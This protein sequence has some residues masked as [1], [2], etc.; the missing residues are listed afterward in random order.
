MVEVVLVSTNRSVLPPEQ[1]ADR[2]H[3]VRL[4]DGSQRNTIRS[5]LRV[6]EEVVAAATGPGT[7]A[8]AAEP[9]ILAQQPARPATPAKLQPAKST[10]AVLENKAADSSAAAAPAAGATAGHASKTEPAAEAVL[11]PAQV[12]PS[13]Q[14]LAPATGSPPRQSPQ[15]RKTAR[16]PPS[17]GP[18][19]PTAH[20][21]AARRAAEG[22]GGDSMSAASYKLMVHMWHQHRAATCDWWGDYDQ[23]DDE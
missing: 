11:V 14:E 6:P 5:R 20:P 13:V 3:T 7:V 22:G 2:G 19:E 4:P 10:L 9:V 23:C 18:S 17:A 12:A 8:A 16:S 1:E 15:P 21:S